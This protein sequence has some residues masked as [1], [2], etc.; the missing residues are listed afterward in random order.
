MTVDHRLDHLEAQ[1]AKALAMMSA[2][3]TPAPMD[4]G[5][6]LFPAGDAIPSKSHHDLLD[7]KI[8][9]LR[10][11][12]NTKVPLRLTKNLSGKAMLRGEE[13]L[14]GKVDRELRQD[15]VQPNDFF[16]LEI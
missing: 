9:I 3:T 5:M 7:G 15:T 12:D 11:R 8:W 10:E 2:E 13:W 4:R 1:L 6:T 16:Y 14:G